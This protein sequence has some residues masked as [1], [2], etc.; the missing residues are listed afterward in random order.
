LA[1]PLARDSSR[2]RGLPCPGTV[3]NPSMP[4]SGTP[5][6]RGCKAVA[7]SPPATT[8]TTLTATQRVVPTGI[9]PTPWARVLARPRVRISQWT[10]PQRPT[11]DQDPVLPE[12]R[13]Y[14]LRPSARKLWRRR[15]V[16]KVKRSHPP[17][18]LPSKQYFFHIDV[19]K[20]GT[21]VII[22]FL[23]FSSF[24]LGHV[25][26][27]VLTHFPLCGLDSIRCR[28]HAQP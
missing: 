28:P 17:S 8:T 4:A 24:R 6:S 15:D 21:C 9:V 16:S 25:A 27:C 19:Q 14:E 3:T 13:K 23:A 18:L 10:R 26:A 2:P 22:P 12:S 1:P 11:A 7:P 20:K 5:P